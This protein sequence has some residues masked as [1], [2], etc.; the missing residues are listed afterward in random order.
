[1]QNQGIAQVEHKG[2]TQPVLNVIPIALAQELAARSQAV[3][4]WQGTIRGNW[5]ELRDFFGFGTGGLTGR[6]GNAE[7]ITF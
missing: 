6:L 5:W 2:R 1:M 3:R 7:T 4:G